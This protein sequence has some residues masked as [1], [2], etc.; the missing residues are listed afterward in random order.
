MT[1][2]TATPILLV[3]DEYMMVEV[4]TAMLAKLGFRD[5]DFACDGE[6][7]LRQLQERSYGLVISD[8]NMPGAG[9]LELAR[10]VRNDPVLKH[11]PFI[12]TTASRDLNKARQA[13]V[14]GVDHYLLKPFRSDVLRAKLELVI[15]KH[16][17][18]MSRMRQAELA[19]DAKA[20]RRGAAESSFGRD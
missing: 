4:I 8:L 15:G 20:Q 3:D 12:M 16:A 5:V 7:A 2:D 1:F 14:A 10:R 6:S 9:G 19:A 17:L 11:T 18:I 13:K